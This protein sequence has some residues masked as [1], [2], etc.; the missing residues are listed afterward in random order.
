MEDGNL[1]EIV[2]GYNYVLTGALAARNFYH[3]GNIGKMVH[4]EPMS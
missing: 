2:Q 3:N 4:L 1:A